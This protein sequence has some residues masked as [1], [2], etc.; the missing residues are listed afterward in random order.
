M[1]CVFTHQNAR[2]PSVGVKHYQQFPRLFSVTGSIFR[3]YVH[4]SCTHQLKMEPATDPKLREHTE[5]TDVSEK[6]HN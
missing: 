2:P 6:D 5:D 1:I 4:G 3:R